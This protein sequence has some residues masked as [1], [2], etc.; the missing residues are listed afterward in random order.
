MTYSLLLRLGAFAALLGGV[1]RLISS[2]IPWVEGSGPLES[3]YFVIDVT[4]LFGLFA[5]YLARAEQ[6]GVVGLV[7]FVI[8]AIGQAAIIGP[9]HAPFDL[10]VYYL[11]TQVIVTGL[12]LV[13]IDMLR[14][15]AYPAWVAGLWIAVPL[16]SLGIGAIDPSPYGWAYF[17]GGLLFSLGFITA[18]AALLNNWAP[19]RK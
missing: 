16:A 14:V 8:A 15:H 9:D 13:A 3:F 6:F 2:F 5:I 10:D 18:G 17:I 11:G 7:G 1:L 4:L 19:A 12:F